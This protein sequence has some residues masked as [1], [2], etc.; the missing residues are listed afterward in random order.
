MPESP[1]P[2]TTP[3]TP[4]GVLELLEAAVQRGL[5]DDAESLASGLERAGWRRD[6]QGGWWTYE[7]DPAWTVGSSVDPAGFSAFATGPDEV[8]AAAADEVAS[9]LSGGGVDGL[10][11]VDLDD[12]GARLWQA[13]A[14]SVELYFSPAKTVELPHKSIEVQCVLQ[15]AAS[16]LDAPSDWQP[17]DHE[18]SRRVVRE[19]SA[20]RRWYLAAQEDLPDDVVQALA[21]DEDPAVVAALE[22]SARQR[23]QW[24]ERV[25][26]GDEDA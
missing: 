17:P 26:G 18:R 1:Q 19:G 12:L 22:V 3:A 23:G 16:R 24:R 20:L 9:H 15:L 13:G 14:V 4:T 5:L 21:L 11:G 8:V 6:T 7:H 2:L 10:V 25:A